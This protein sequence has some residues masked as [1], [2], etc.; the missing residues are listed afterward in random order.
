MPR[1]RPQEDAGS[2]FIQFRGRQTSV[3]VDD[4]GVHFGTERRNGRIV[5][6]AVPVIPDDSDPRSSDVPSNGVVESVAEA[7]V[8][9]NPMICYGVACEHPDCQAVFESPQAVSSHQSA[10]TDGSDADGDGDT[11]D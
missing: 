4:V 3:T 9:A 2:D 6:E 1:Q 7:L 5:H 10:H 11:D 8:A